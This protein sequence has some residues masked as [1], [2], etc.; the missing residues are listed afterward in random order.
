MLY[1]KNQTPSL[2][3]SLF[4]SPTSEYRCT[5][6]W[7]WND[8]LK[9]DELCRQIDEMK[10]M[11]FG[12]FHM[13]TRSGMATPYLSDEFM[14]L[15]KTCNEKAKKENMLA[16]LYDE[17]RWPSGAAGGLVTK[18]PQ[19]RGKIVRFTVNPNPAVE[20]VRAYSNYVGTQGGTVP[21]PVVDESTG[22]KQGNYYL[23]A[24]Y[25]IVLTQD[26]YLKSCRMVTPGDPVEGT[27]WYAY[28]EYVRPSG[29][30]NGQAYVDTLSDEAMRRFID[31]TYEAYLKAVGD[32]FD[33]S[34]P[35]IF[36]DE[37][38]FAH[39]G[40]LSFAAARQDV[41]IPWTLDLPET[42][43]ASYGFDLIPYLPELLWDPAGRPSKA[44]YLY[45]DHICE[46][47]TNAFAKQ[48][49]TW[50]K[51]HGLALTGHM[52]CEQTLHSQSMTVGE[53]MRAYGWF[54]LPGIDMLCNAVE[55][56][57]AKQCQS[58]VHQFGKEGMLSELYGVTGWDFDFR[59]HKFQGD[60]QAALGVT[61]R[62]PHLSWYSMRGSAKRDYPASIHY[63]SAWY[64]EYACIEDHFARLNTAL[65]RGKPA[66]R[67]AVI[68]PVE[69]YWLAYG[70]AE[71]TAERRAQLEANF[72]NILNWMLR[73]TIDFDFISESV[74]PE[75]LIP[76]DDGKLH[77]GEMTYEAVVMPGLETIRSTTVAALDKFS[78]DGGRVVL[79]GDDPTFVDAEIPADRTALDSLSAGAKHISFSKVALLGALGDLRDVEIRSMSGALSDSL[80]YNKR[81]DADCDWLFV[82]H[83]RQ[84]DQ[85]YPDHVRIT[86]KGR[87]R[88]E[89]YDTQSGEIK[90]IPYWFTPAGDT[91][92]Q[93]MIYAT[94]SLLLR[95]VPA[96]D[97]DKGTVAIVGLPPKHGVKP[98]RMIDFKDKA[99]VSLSEPNV[100]VL[101]MPEWSEDGD[102]FNGREEMLRI[103]RLLRRKYGFPAADGRDVQPWCIPEEKITIFPYLRFTFNSEV[104]AVCKLAYEGLSSVNL[105]G[106]DVPVTDDGYFT[107]RHIRTMPLPALKVG[108]NVLTVRAPFGK[109]VSLENMFLLGDF[110]VAVSGTSADVK[111]PG[112]TA[113][114]G[115]VVHQ[116]LPFYGADMTYMLPVTLDKP[117][118]VVAVVQS[119]KGAL[120]TVKV[121]GKPAGRIIHAP[122]SLEV[123]GLAAGEHTLE[124][125]LHLS[126]VN[127]F[128]ALHN[129]SRDTW[130]GPEFWYS[131]DFKWAYEYQ[132]KD[133]GILKSP[134]VYV[135]NKE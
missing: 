9:A 44:R 84:I 100:L 5:P 77:V 26:G 55:L 125:T 37:P 113:A 80:I 96:A 98:D 10:E 97:D 43:F 87:V 14:D 89:L 110:N 71:S 114:F 122:Y 54:G 72:D 20:D 2:D 109:R 11:G 39:M 63:Q 79:M 91:V 86:M 78:K 58:A 31:I 22:Y 117:A 35:A 134:L 6:F 105:N 67:V 41:S 101:D 27:L 112:R 1:K 126:R 61:V 107:D 12:G 119:Y 88:P 124:L 133:N 66:V 131:A 74:L 30:Y 59:G 65:T 76:S 24:A 106:V 94:D 36:T 38:Q 7:A 81:H 123:D 40:T 92:V 49:G 60:W 90:E 33:K 102:T 8:K 52:L 95:L 47:F 25:D 116:G 17:D 103:D 32:D 4:S 34:V 121:D 99:A 83:V 28:A 21:C 18:D 68:H 85:Y 118:D 127:C 62:V 115:S 69:S 15:I 50:C 73:G 48:C 56:S 104:P 70:P 46:R 13:H 53:T 75:L 16:W 64:K 120:I 23:L 108:E 128:G 42:F 57:T 130:I 82:A 3:K 111:A 129:C 132:L 19:Y 29:W 135:Y 51:E 93:A 45:H